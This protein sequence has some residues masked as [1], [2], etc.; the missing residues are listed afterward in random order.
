MCTKW[1]NPPERNNMKNIDKAT[2]LSMYD[3]E[4][5]SFKEITLDE[6]PEKAKELVTN[7]L[8]RELE[9]FQI[10]M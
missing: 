7:W 9:K 6:V 8:T 4:T 3:A 1:G 10:D 2:K 5:C